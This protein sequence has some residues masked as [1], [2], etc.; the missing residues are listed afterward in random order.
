MKPMVVVPQAWL[1]QE[2]T[3][4]K[5]QQKRGHE[6]GA[7]EGR[8]DGEGR[9]DKSP[10]PLVEE[11]KEKNALEPEAAGADKG[12]GERCLVLA[13]LTIWSQTADCQE[14]GLKEVL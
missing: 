4:Q 11:Q 12:R 7:S 5:M 9:K 1:M 14:A 3:P 13:S 2:G 6:A 8:V 10:V